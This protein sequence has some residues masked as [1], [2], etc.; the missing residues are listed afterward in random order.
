MQSRTRPDASEE[1]AYLVLRLGVG[2]ALAYALWL[3]LQGP[4]AVP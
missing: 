2:A 1:L 3:A 4:K